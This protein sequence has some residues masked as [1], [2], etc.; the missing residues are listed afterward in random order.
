[1]FANNFVFSPD[2]YLQMEKN[3][4]YKRT[5]KE[6]NLVFQSIYNQY[7]A[8]LCVFATTILS[9][10][11]EAEEIVQKVIFK[12]WEQ[13]ETFDSIENLQS[14]LYRSVKN[15]CINVIN[16]KKIED[17]YKSEAWDELKALEIKSIEPEEETLYNEA[18]LKQA[19][20]KLPDRSKEVLIMSKFEGLKHKEIAEQLNI[21]VKAVEASITRAFSIL[22]KLLQETP[23]H[24][25]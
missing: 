1:M 2:F 21:S 8:K 23:K 9:D 3:E 10:D 7:Y 4:S 6:W 19:I 11:I 24:N 15:H 12:L 22:R 14:Y 17:R 20:Q 16:H 25:L 13:R 5:D 18:K